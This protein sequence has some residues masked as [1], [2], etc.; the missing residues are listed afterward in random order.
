[1]KDEARVGEVLL[2]TL[3]RCNLEVAD[4]WLKVT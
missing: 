4:V 1:M 3:W 2:G